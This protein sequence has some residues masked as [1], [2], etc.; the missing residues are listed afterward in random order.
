MRGADALIAALEREGVDTVFGIPGGA[1]LAL[2]DAL[3]DSPIRHVLT[4]HEAGAGHAA[5][6]Y[7]RAT[8]RVGVAFGTS[9]PGATNLL[10]PICDAY[11]DSTPTVFVTGQVRTDL[12][13][14]NAFQEADVIGMSAPMVKHS[15]AVE[16]ADEIAQA[17]HDA[18][19]LARSGRPGPVLVDVPSDLARAP[20]RERP[21]GGQPSDPAR[22]PGDRASDLRQYAPESGVTCDPKQ[23]R[24]AAEAI[25]AARRPVLYAGGGVVHAEAADELTA[26]ARLAEL[27]VTTTLMALGAFPASDRRWLGMLG[28]HG[29]RTAN[30]AIDEA[31]LIVAVGARFDDR[32]TGDLAQWAPHA[33][34]VHLDVDASEIG[35]LRAAD[36]PLVADARE[37]LAAIRAAYAAL[38]PTPDPSRL[39]AWWERLDAWRA[40][41]RERA[42]GKQAI[43]PHH[44]LDALQAATSG[45][46]IVATDVGQHQMWAANRLRFERPRRWLTSGGHGT[47]GFGLPAALGAQAALP[48]AQVVC[49]SG[50]GS[51]LM[52]VQELATA[53]Q[54]SLPVKVIVMNNGCLGMVR[55]QQDMFWD[56]RRSAVELGASP[57]WELLA[58]A[59]GVAGCTVREPGD[60]EEAVA[61]TLAE[62]GPALLDVRIAPTADALPMFKPGGAAREMIS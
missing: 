28:M 36:V 10:T 40:A 29:T 23:A 27:P 50:E 56:G 4:R 17:I 42:V 52:N 61:R 60:V 45:E 11:M 14:T 37:G 57:D 53:V 35:K 5:E 3:L 32:V 9:G 54:E 41:E 15:I 48:A 16:S 24:R 38:D 1:N 55:Q 8:G 59:F 43:D 49:V 7:A 62:P 6:G 34:V 18:F 51:L 39:A 12:R 25:A 21:R 13:G 22:L 19:A 46:A 58:R 47:M 20:A 30:W 31:D 44:V 33:K 2:Y 26:L